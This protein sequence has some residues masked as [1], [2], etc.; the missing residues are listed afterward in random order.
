MC[1]KIILEPFQIDENR[2]F[3][4]QYLHTQVNKIFQSLNLFILK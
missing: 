3:S 4:Q 1:E 2:P